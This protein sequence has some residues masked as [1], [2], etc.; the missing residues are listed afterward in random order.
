MGMVSISTVVTVII[1]NIFHRGADTHTM[2]TW[3]KTIFIDS[4][5]AKYLW[6][7]RPADYLSY[8]IT[9]DEEEHEKKAHEMA[10]CNQICMT[11][12][13]CT[14]S[15]ALDRSCFNRNAFGGGGKVNNVN[16]KPLNRGSNRETSKLALNPTLDEGMEWRE[17][18]TGE[19][20]D[21]E[22]AMEGENKGLPA[23][24]REGLNY[25]N[26]IVDRTRDSDKD[27]RVII[28][29]FQLSVE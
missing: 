11:T 14:D 22:S 21:P 20:I 27:K 10:N 3:V 12:H 26:F 13:S 1:I 18:E 9:C 8:N 29:R 6:V 7:E 23:R 5:M 2:P 25:I 19:E 24:L 4:N 16:Y 17:S 15:P 28:I